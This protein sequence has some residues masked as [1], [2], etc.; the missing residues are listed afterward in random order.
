MH[1]NIRYSIYVDGMYDSQPLC[2]ILDTAMRTGT[3]LTSVSNEEN[4]K[5]FPLEQKT[6]ARVRV[7][8][9][10]ISICLTKYLMVRKRFVLVLHYYSY[11]SGIFI[12]PRIRSTFNFP[13]RY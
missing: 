5:E 2:N 4:G 12:V 3:S 1:L 10:I 9:M 7:L 13:G 11:I 8:Y 6:S